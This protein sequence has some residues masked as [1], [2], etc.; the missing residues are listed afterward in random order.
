ML[1][2]AAFVPMRLGRTLATHASTPVS[3]EA[4][5]R[6]WAR[7]EIQ[8]LYD[9]PLLDLVF[10]AAAVHRKHHDPSKIQLCTLMNIK[11]MSLTRKTLHYVHKPPFHQP[12]DAQRTVSRSWMNNHVVLTNA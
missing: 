12:E 6:T 1:R 10:R 9:T 7:Q 3:A 4:T 5:R 11:S 2:Y 8:D